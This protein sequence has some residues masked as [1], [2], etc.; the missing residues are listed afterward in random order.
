MN[1]RGKIIQITGNLV[2]IEYDLDKRISTYSKV[3]DL[4]MGDLV[5]FYIDES[6]EGQI[7]DGYSQAKIKRIIKENRNN[8]ITYSNQRLSKIAR[9]LNLGIDNIV[10][11]LRQS[12]FAL[13]NN[14]NQKITE[15]QIKLLIKSFSNE[16]TQKRKRDDVI[17]FER[18]IVFE[19]RIKRIINPSLIV[20]HGPEDKDAYL[21]LQNLAWNYARAERSFLQ[22]KEKNLIEVV[23]LENNLDHILVSRKHLMT[24]PYELD[25]WKNIKPGDRLKGTVSELLHSIVI[26]KTE[27]DFFGKHKI[28]NTDKTEYE[29]GKEFSFVIQGK[30]DSNFF[31]SLLEQNEIEEAITQEINISEDFQ[32]HDPDLRSFQAISKSSYFKNANKEDKESIKQMFQHD[33]NLFSNAI[34]LPSTLYFK[35]RSNG[36]AW[37]ND[38]KHSLIPYLFESEYQE[39][40]EKEAIHFLENQKYWV[41]VNSRVYDGR[42]ITQWV[43]FNEKVYLFGD[44]LID[45]TKCD[46]LIRH[47]TVERTQKKSSKSKENNLNKGTFLFTSPVRFLSP[48][49][50]GPLE[51]SQMELFVLLQNKSE[52]FEIINK[53]K[54]QTG[55][56]IKEEGLSIAIFDKF[57]EYQMAQARQGSEEARFFVKSNKYRRVPSK[58]G[59]SNTIA[60]EVDM[61]FEDYLDKQS[62]EAQLLTVKIEQK[63]LKTEKDTEFIWFADAWVGQSCDKTVMHFSNLDKTIDLLNDG[64]FIE[65][66]MSVR[67]YQVQREVIKD[68][69]DKRLKLEHIESLLLKPD[70]I[71]HPDEPELDYINPI[72][73]ETEKKQPD[74][75]QIKAVKKAVGN[76]NIYLIQGPPGT[77]KTTVIA[78]VVEQ[79]VRKEE[80]V[81]VASQTHIAVDNVLE[82]VSKNKLLNCIRIGN[83]QRI[84]ENLKKFHIDSLIQT[85]TD[86]FE[87]LIEVNYE[88]AECFKV[89]ATQDSEKELKLNLK[90]LLKD[91]AQNYS[92]NIRDIFLQKNYEFLSIL[93]D[94]SIEQIPEIL[95]ILKE[96]SGDV[97]HEREVLLK[98]LLIK[99]ADVVFAT[100]I[101]IRTNK[102]LTEYGLKFDTVIID[103]AGKANISESLAAISMAKKVILVG[104]QMQL[105]PYFDENML[106]ETD[107]ASFPRS[108]YGKDYLKE[109]IE[110]AVKISFFEFLVNKI[111][112]GEFPNENIELLNYQHRMHPHIGEFISNSFYNGM[113]KMGEKTFENKLSM[114]A[115]F[116]KEIVFINT[117]ASKNPYE[118]FDGYSAQ[119]ETEAM[120]ISSIVIPKLIEAGLKPEH[121]AIVAPYKSQVAMIKRHLSGIEQSHKI[122][123]STLDSFQ[124]MEFDVIIFS[125]TRSASPAQQNKKVGFL[126][127][128]RRLNVAFSRAK[129]KLILVGNAKTL[130]DRSSHFDLLFNYTDLFRKLV[131]LSKEERIGNYV[132]L[133]DFKDLKK[134]FELFQE[135]HPVGSI[136]IGLV[137][138]I[139][140]YGAFVNVGE[141]DGLIYIADLSWNRVN[142][143]NEILQEGQQIKVIVLGYDNKKGYTSL[144]FKQLMPDPFDNIQLNEKFIGDIVKIEHYGVFVKLSNDLR[145][146]LHKSEISKVKR[147]NLELHYYV[148]MPLP[149]IINKINKLKREI[150]LKL[151]KD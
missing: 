140:E 79:L 133:T 145:G 95:A 122:D 81:L 20:L 83:K 78:E 88:L 65:K 54:Q 127:D 61:D 27:L 110:K 141:V 16:N 113:V 75:N 3:R 114:P 24:K 143:P 5:E 121:F 62:E 25:A 118:S 151:V 28:T 105:P 74:N 13:D 37:E 48:K 29:A 135:K 14:P 100:C 134:P 104:D 131:A 39:D 101:G 103:E 130:A 22:L 96:W 31:L 50:A 9:E 93:L 117:S 21:P 18:G 82:K 94:T 91:R 139:E 138:K 35:F 72:F 116:D 26:V 32:T 111:S 38:F 148:G 2:Y 52:A 10:D 44:V 1:F 129:K 23:V 124:G 98:P 8:D 119:N 147:K 30:D 89:S 112:K 45:T 80:R 107:A 60:I 49:T 12:G 120:C 43:L 51:L 90:E 99:S 126:D 73:V 36:T 17:H 108:K 128:A 149:V 76:N 97:E 4:N 137:K 42:L 53:L 19:T 33:A 106:D 123:V 86:D 136:L 34:A 6:S 142:H 69:F 66:K 85:F 67:Q 70:S 71:L 57:L 15:E 84:K 63:S 77:G 146:L 87:K 92:D 68:F 56:L 40:K 59:D 7:G 109:D 144:G 64:F 125:F 46:F 47:L 102:E 115:P 11:I 132:N 55:A 41:R 58:T 150:S